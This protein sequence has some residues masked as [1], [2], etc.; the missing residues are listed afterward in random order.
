M[1]K[2]IFAVLFSTLAFNALATDMKKG[3]ALYRTTCAVCHA[4]GV[5]KAPKTHDVAAWN[6]RFNKALAIAKKQLPNASIK[7]QK[8]KAMDILAITVKNGLGA[9]PPGGMCPKCN[10]DDYKS[11]IEYMMSKKQS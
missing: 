1:K 11:A 3:E 7:A 9:M 4:N 6:E 5:A 10:L 8:A 2:F